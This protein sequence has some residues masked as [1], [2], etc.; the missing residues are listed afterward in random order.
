V[1]TATTLPPDLP[2][3]FEC[4]DGAGGFR[5][6]SVTAAELAE[7]PGTCRAQFAG[8]FDE[9]PDGI[10]LIG[11][12]GIRFG[13]PW[14][15]DFA[16]WGFGD[17]RREMTAL[18]AGLAGEIGAVKAAVWEFPVINVSFWWWLEPLPEDGGDDLD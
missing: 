4:H 6:G 8:T 18:A 17:L 7:R 12:P 10:A 3:S 1:A 2:V 14:H 9:C 16:G 13:I 5:S 11:K 15:R